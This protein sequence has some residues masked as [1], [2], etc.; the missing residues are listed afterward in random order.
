M[1]IIL[2]SGGVLGIVIEFYVMKSGMY[3]ISVIILAVCVI[4]LFLSLG[5]LVACFF[6][7]F[8]NTDNFIIKVRPKELDKSTQN[9]HLSG[10]FNSNSL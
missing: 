1:L 4:V 3:M 5:I 2:I 10:C 7:L 9:T 8:I 6:R